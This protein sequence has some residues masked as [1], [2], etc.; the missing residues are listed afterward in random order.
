MRYIFILFALFLMLGC[1]KVTQENYKKITPGMNYDAVVNILGKPNSCDSVANST[2]CVWGS[3]SK[4]IKVRF[5]NN[6][7]VVISSQGLE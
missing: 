5:V 2:S 7:A 1:S 4:N 3:I 6:R